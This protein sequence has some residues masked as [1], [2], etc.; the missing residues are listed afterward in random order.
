MTINERIQ[1]ILENA[2]EISSGDLLTGIETPFR[3]LAGPGAGK[4]H[5]LIEHIKQVIERSDRLGPGQRIACISYTTVAAKEIKSRLGSAVTHVD[6]STIHSFL[7]RNI[8]KPYLYWVKDES[9]KPVVDY[10]HVDGH[11]PHKSSYGKVRTWFKIDGVT[12]WG[13]FSSFL[14][15]T[16]TSEERVYKFFQSLYWGWGDTDEG[17]GW[18]LCFDNKRIPDKKFTRKPEALLEYKRLF[19]EQGI[20]DHEDVLYFAVRI[21]EE[22][23]GIA[24]FLSSRYPYVFV[25]EFQ[26]TTPIQTKVLRVLADAGTVTGVIGDVEQAIFEFTGANPD[27]L[28]GFTPDGQETYYITANRRSTKAILQLL[29]HVRQGA[30]Q[31]LHL[32][33]GED[34]ISEGEAPVIL[35]GSSKE[36]YE[37]V[38]RVC[39]SEFKTLTRSNKLVRLLTG[40]DLPDGDYEDVW[41]NLFDADSYRT[42]WLQSVV[43]ATHELEANEEK[44]EV[45]YGH[46]AKILYRGMRTKNGMLLKKVFSKRCRMS[47]E[48]RR[49]AAAALLPQLITNHD[50]HLDM[51]GLEFYQHVQS[52]VESLLPN[53]K[54]KKPTRGKFA[55]R[56][57]ETTFEALYKTV[58][59]NSGQGAVK[60]IHKAKGEEYHTVLV[61]RGSRDK[62]RDVTLDHLLNPEEREDEERRVTYVGLSRAK[63]R[64]FIGVD[65]LSEEE[66][67]QMDG[68]GLSVERLS[69]TD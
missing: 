24:R 15:E 46:A 38:K 12:G 22:N 68:L 62:K 19:W 16:D 11:R 14:R 37:Y 61:Y 51:N 8:V 69:S 7:Y 50:R 18:R 13:S 34:E 56:L 29:N 52:L 66:E 41:E 67:V 5:W 27:D 26:D 21:I 6:V 28:A 39:T 43:E 47:R 25:D 44:K 48:Q 10:R 42:E 59:L 53:V 40:A 1:T 58:S 63:E 54:M 55:D 9:G 60:T 64:L 45:P 4:T 17:E 30:N 2:E 23:R 33:D 20:I 3:I 65:E 32:E 35:V 31:E 57:K 36:V 49:R